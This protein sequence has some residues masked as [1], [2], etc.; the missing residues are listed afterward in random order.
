MEKRRLWNRSFAQLFCIELALQFGLYLVRPIVANYSVSLGASMTLAGFFSGLLATTALLM[1][2]FSGRIS[3]AFSKKSLLVISSAF[4]TVSAF[5]CSICHTLL[6]LGV[7]IS[8]QGFAFA[9][10]STVVVSM[11]RLIV[12]QEMVG[13]G[14][15]WLGVAY[16]VS[17]AL[18][19]AAGS[20]VGGAVGY[21]GSFAVSAMLL[22]VGLVLSATFKEPAKKD[23]SGWAER[24]SVE[25]KES[26]S[27]RKTLTSFFY[28]PVLS[29]TIVAGLL[30]ATQGTTASFMLLIGEMRGIQGA[31]VYFLVYSLATLA[32]RPIAGR[33]SDTCGVKAVAVPMLALAAIA[34][35][36][37]AFFDTITGIVVAGICMGLG[38]GSAYSA[39]QA[40]SV[41]NVPYDQLGRAANTFYIGPDLGM[42]LGPVV[43]GFILQTWGIAPAFLFCAF[44]IIVS[45]V[46][47]LFRKSK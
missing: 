9:F 2:P 40:E 4:F 18:G 46:I 35:T 17:C 23:F 42:G 1:R 19:P 21:S 36:A 34:P 33:M 24:S 8:L 32:A 25:A 28:M 47:L 3:D 22:F 45:L 20:F 14:V 27:S 37:L 7:L 15:G 41:R 39:I 26:C 13:R 38:Q 10:K 12:P 11:A 29:L 6:P 31:S 5:G 16:T 44:L 30:M 43:S